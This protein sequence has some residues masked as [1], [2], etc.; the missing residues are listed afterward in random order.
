MGNSGFEKQ[1]KESDSSSCFGKRGAC[2][3][4]H[5][6]WISAKLPLCSDQQLSDSTEVCIISVTARLYWC[7]FHHGN[8]S[9]L[10]STRGASSRRRSS[11]SVGLI[12]AKVSLPPQSCIVFPLAG[13][14]FPSLVIWKMRVDLNGTFARVNVNGT[15][16]QDVEE[17]M[18]NCKHDLVVQWRLLVHCEAVEHELFRDVLCIHV[19]VDGY[20][21]SGFNNAELSTVATF[22]AP[23][24]HF[25]QVGLKKA[26]NNIWFCNG[27]QDFVEYHSICYGYILV[28][29]Y[30]GN[31][32]FHVLIFDKIATEIQYPPRKNCKLK[33]HQV[34]IIYLDEDD[35][36]SS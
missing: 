16:W 18:Q 36:N 13:I 2:S 23:Y 35:T 4:Y 30:E 9:E 34:E 10:R 25:C 29:K 8:A 15:P 14:S 12:H 26:D 7:M 31:S 27:W 19:S 24:P 3:L 5:C 1:N 11:C 6:V 22:I 33:D 17:H 20:S 28:S 32:S 21:W